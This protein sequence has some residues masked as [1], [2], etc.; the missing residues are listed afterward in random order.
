MTTS[1]KP[2]ETPNPGG[3]YE[4]SGRCVK[5]AGPAVPGGGLYV[6]FGFQYGGCE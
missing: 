3:R 4:P 2:G 1:F 5:P 6:P